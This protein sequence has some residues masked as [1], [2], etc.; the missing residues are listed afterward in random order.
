[1]IKNFE[2]CELPST[3][4]DFDITKFKAWYP[5]QIKLYKDSKAPRCRKKLTY[6]KTKNK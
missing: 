6:K 1:M 5:S 4:T 3:P 2:F